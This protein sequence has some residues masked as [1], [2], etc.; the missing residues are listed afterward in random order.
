M[1]RA[2]HHQ[3]ILSGVLMM[4]FVLRE[5]GVSVIPFA[6]HNRIAV[7]AGSAAM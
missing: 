7:Q 1:H 2:L 6:I 5:W 3:L 4:K